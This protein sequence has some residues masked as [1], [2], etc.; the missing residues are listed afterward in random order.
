[1]ILKTHC[2]TNLN[3][4]SLLL[5]CHPLIVLDDIFPIIHRWIRMCYLRLEAPLRGK[6]EKKCKIPTLGQN[7]YVHACIHIYLSEFF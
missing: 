4:W 7:L 6:L 3:T 1:M 2:I 5:L